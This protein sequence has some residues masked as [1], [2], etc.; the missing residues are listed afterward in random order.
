M[1]YYLIFLKHVDNTINMVHAGPPHHIF[2]P[3]TQINPGLS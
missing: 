3:G 2:G 1:Y